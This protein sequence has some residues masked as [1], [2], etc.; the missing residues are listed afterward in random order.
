MIT[1]M[2]QSTAGWM[3][4]WFAHLLQNSVRTPATQ[5]VNADPTA[6]EADTIASFNPARQWQTSPMSRTVEERYRLLPGDLARGPRTL[7]ISGVS[8]QG[9]EN[10]QL[11]L[12]FA[13]TRKALALTTVQCRDLIRSTGSGNV[14]NWVGQPLLLRTQTIDDLTTI[15]IGLDAPGKV[16]S[17]STN[18]LQ[19]FVYSFLFKTR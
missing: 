12:H 9:V 7:R 18:R 2:V 4:T 19:A 8:Y 13:E 6:A 10:V 11:V 15:Q 17:P 14:D 3:R 1:Y 5:P 16:N